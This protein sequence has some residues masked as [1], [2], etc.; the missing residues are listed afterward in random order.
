MGGVV[1]TLFLQPEFILIFAAGVA[2]SG[3]AELGALLEDGTIL[4]R[5]AK[6]T[7]T[8]IDTYSVAKSINRWMNEGN[9]L[10]G[11]KDGV[12]LLKNGTLLFTLDGR[13]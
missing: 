9:E 4:R 11:K 12:S 2:D 3:L 5:L 13:E 7:S 6:I 1:V 10:K 8:T